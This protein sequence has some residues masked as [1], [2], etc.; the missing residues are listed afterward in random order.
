Y[1]TYVIFI[2][3]SLF[4]YIIIIGIIVAFPAMPTSHFVL[5]YV[6]QIEI[7]SIGTVFI[8]YVGIGLIGM[9]LSLKK[10]DCT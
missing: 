2:H 10:T 4:V 1:W 8:G 7:L 3:V 5:Y 6:S 9:K